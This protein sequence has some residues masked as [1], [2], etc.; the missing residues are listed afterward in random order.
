MS[1]WRPTESM[2][3][4]GSDFLICS[5]CGTNGET[6]VDIARWDDDRYAKRPRPHVSTGSNRVMRDRALII[7]GWMPLPKT[8]SKAVT[9]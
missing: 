1:K 9:K 2:P 5:K 7:L 4:D 6:R 8:I 3:R